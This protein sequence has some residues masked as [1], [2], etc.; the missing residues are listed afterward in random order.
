MSKL[1]GRQWEAAVAGCE[2]RASPPAG[3][4]AARSRSFTVGGG[5]PPEPAAGTAAPRLARCVGVVGALAGALLSGGCVN[6]QVDGDSVAVASEQAEPAPRDDGPK[7][8][9][10][11]SVEGKVVSVRTDLRYVIID[12]SFS[13]LPEP[14]AEMA[15]IR[16]GKRVGKVRITANPSQARGGAVVA[17]IKEGA[18][19][20]GDLV[21]GIL[22]VGS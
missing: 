21:R 8:E 10:A 15:L 4:P 20:A 13:R 19:R 5:T 17:D 12:F 2:K 1:V 7:F 9:V 3:L 14:G 22:D 18:A 6:Q 11:S 16:D